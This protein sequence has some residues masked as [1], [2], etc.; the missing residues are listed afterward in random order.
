MSEVKVLVGGAT[1]AEVLRLEEPLSFWGGVDPVTGD[2]IEKRHPQYGESVS[3]RIVSMPRGRGSSSAS[4][5]LAE[6]LRLGQG[7][8][9]LVLESGDAILV[10]GALVARELY[11][12]QCPIVVSGVV[13]Q[14]GETWS[15]EDAKISRVSS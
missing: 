7:P 3:G 9:G 10:A 8:A 5:I 11:D 1:T 15:I 13:M 14:T 6:A 4:S 12:V 2:I